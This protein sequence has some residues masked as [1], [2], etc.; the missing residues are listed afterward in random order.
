MP[1]ENTFTRLRPSGNQQQAVTTRNNHPVL[2]M[3][4]LVRS[5]LLLTWRI[6]DMKKRRHVACSPHLSH[7]MC[8]G[9]S[10][11]VLTTT[12]Q[13]ELAHVLAQ[14]RQK[15]YPRGTRFELRWRA[16]RLRAGCTVLKSCAACL[17][18]SGQ[19]KEATRTGGFCKD[20]SY[21]PPNR[22]VPQHLRKKQKQNVV[23]FSSTAGTLAAPDRRLLPAHPAM[24]SSAWAQASAWRAPGARL[25][26][27]TT[28]P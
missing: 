4:V 27:C 22:S 5:G 15:I 14:G 6:A 24:R 3:L 21:C 17:L 8:I 19:R 1:Q 25:Q 2:H 20:P 10:V 23:E 13:E 7:L 9:A 28:S 12:L 18:L 16:L 26:T 11:A